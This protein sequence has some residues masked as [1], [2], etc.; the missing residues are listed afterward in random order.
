M[1]KGGIVFAMEDKKNLGDQPALAQAVKTMPRW[2]WKVLAF[3]LIVGCI[4]VA[5]QAITMFRK[6]PA[7]EPQKVVVTKTVPATPAPGNEGGAPSGSSGFVGGAPSATPG[8]ATPQTT[9]VTTVT[10]PA[11]SPSS[12]LTP[13]MTRV[14]FSLFVGV[15]VGLIF[16][17]FFKIA[18]MITTLI[19][20]A[21][22]ALSYFQI[23]NVDM[24]LV[25]NETAHATSWLSD[26]GYRLKD[27][28]FSALPSS[29]SA[30][31]GFFMGF[32]K[33]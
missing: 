32:K 21:A 30:A 18:L 4:G 15:I 25:K 8:A 14:G 7:P 24:T 23:L 10:T 17:T 9:T 29:T 5:G 28:L 26:Q 1:T 19:I 20:G 16:R 22:M 31:V 13:F 2:K 27:M 6:G 3:A 11:D 12:M 33:R